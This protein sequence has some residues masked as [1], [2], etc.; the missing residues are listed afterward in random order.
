MHEALPRDLAVAM[1]FV[2]ANGGG[3]AV[4][5]NIRA[6][7]LIEMCARLEPLSKAVMQQAPSHIRTLCGKMPVAMIGAL[8]DGT[9][10]PDTD[11][12]RC[13]VHGFKSVGDVPDSGVFAPG[14]KPFEAIPETVLAGN[15]SYTSS[16]IHQAAKHATR[17]PHEAS[18][19]W[20]KTMSDVDKGLCLGPFTRNHL[21]KKVWGYGRWRPMPRFGVWQN[22]KLRPIDDGKASLHN[23]ITC[24]RESL[25]C[26]RADFPLR[27]ARS[28]AIRFGPNRR[29]SMKVGT[30]DIASAYRLIPT[31]HP[32]YTVFGV[33]D[34]EGKV[35]FF[36]LPGH[37][38]GL[39]S[40]V[41]N[42]NRVPR[43]AVFLARTLLGVL[44]NHFYDDCVIAEPDF[45]AESGQEMMGII[46]RLLGL[47]FSDEKHVP[48]DDM[49]VFLGVVSDFSQL[50]T[51]GIMTLRIKPERRSNLMQAISKHLA[52]K[53]LSH[54]D[55]AELEGK[56]A[57]SILSQF[58]RIG[59]AALA[60]IR[61]RARE[62]GVS[63]L[64]PTISKA[65]SFFYDL[66]RDMP[67]FSTPAYPISRKP[68]LVW[69]DAMFEKGGVRID[70]PARGCTAAIG[71]IVWSP[72]DRAYFHSRLVII[73]STFARALV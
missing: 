37:P 42:F 62:C 41:L 28:L 4:K 33:A 12:V 53:R 7:R 21:D 58:G 48:V 18:E 68:V 66:L 55:A 45:S 57:F 73:S 34:P 6:D 3:V 1:D 69:T 29:F 22:G 24:T 43:F 44:V 70:S 10:W 64:T 65:L 13:F 2:V 11:L 61:V 49:A 72:N 67:P 38:F 8:I 47:P 5:R 16:V 9:Q 20:R 60:V 27:V 59:R 56:L 19:L 25:R 51:R 30:D 52:A 36:C 32:W 71:A 50:A 54:H 15:A 17:N 35:H 26:C 63:A 23:A 14:G 39:T 40:A 46:M 31:A